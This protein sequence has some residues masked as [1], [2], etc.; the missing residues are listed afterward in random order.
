MRELRPRDSSP[1]I[2]GALAASAELGLCP[3]SGCGLKQTS[4]TADKEWFN[5]PVFRDGESRWLWTGGDFLTFL[6]A[7]YWHFWPHSNK[8]GWDFPGNPVVRTLCFQCRVMA[9]I[10]GQ[11]TKIPHAMQCGQ[12]TKKKA[13]LYGRGCT[14]PTH[15]LL[16]LLLLSLQSCSTLCDRIDGSPPGSPIPG[17]L[18][19]RTLEWV[20]ISFS[21]AWKWKVKEVA[22]L[23]PTLSDPMDCSLP[24]SS[25]HGIFQARVLEWGAIAFSK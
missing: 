12:K 15:L 4:G 5:L 11:G 6:L 8:P 1:H 14:S 3:R 22:Q 16:L 13:R 20:A 9:L 19:A 24:G 25:T 2:Q 23:C 21:N 7:S 10:P 17:I 18:Q